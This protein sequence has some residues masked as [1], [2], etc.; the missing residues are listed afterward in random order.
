MIEIKDLLVNFRNVLLG[1]EI[2]KQI[3]SEV[4]YEVVHLKIS[5]NDIEIKNGVLFLNTKPI[6]KNEI[7]IKKD[8]IMRKIDLSLGKKSPSK[9]F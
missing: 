8:E 1:E 3:I 2:K 6:Y 7:F 4:L 9:I 5:T